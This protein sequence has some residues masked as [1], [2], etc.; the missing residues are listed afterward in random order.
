MFHRICVGCGV[1]FT[2]QGNRAKACTVACRLWAKRHP[3][4]L[5]SLA[6]A[7]PTC[8]GTFTAEHA[9]TVYC[10]RRCSA[11]ASKRRVRTGVRPYAPALAECEA[12]HGPMPAGKNAGARFCTD[13]CGDRYYRAPGLFAARFGR[14]C[15]RCGGPVPDGKRVDA[16][17][18][19]TTCQVVWN[20]EIRRAR[21]RG[22]PVEPIDRAAIFERDKWACHL[23]TLPITARPTLDHLI[24]IAAADS[25]GHVWE[26]V[27]AAHG[28]CNSGK[29]DRVT[30]HDRELYVRLRAERWALVS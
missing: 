26:N 27:A 21:R 18:C 30:D 17:F 16:R 6:R 29:R 15:E 25:P 22:L 23:C 5:R 28:G 13:I 9:A 4:V 14:T 11:A 24:P 12:C 7:C 8:G 1:Q 3:G 2:A 10:S 19:R 20:Q